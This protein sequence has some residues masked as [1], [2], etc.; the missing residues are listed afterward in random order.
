MSNLI[1]IAYPDKS[2][3]EQVAANLDEARKGHLIELDDLVLV[4][5]R[6]DGKIKLHQPSMATT[7]ALGGA[8]WGGLI[9]LLFLVPFFGMAIGAATGAAAGA[10]TDTGVDDNFMKELG[11]Q[12][13]PGNVALVALVRN[14]NMEKVLADVKIPGRILHSSLDEET[15][16]R[17][18]DALAKAGSP[19]PAA[20]S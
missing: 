12:L 20:A 15:E 19:A 10:M 8:A 14:A 3:A 2:T 11:A 7:G 1:A 4:E 6:D 16:K 5:R 18:S 17:L 13:Q 9:G